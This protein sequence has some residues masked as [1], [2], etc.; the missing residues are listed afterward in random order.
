[1]TLFLDGICSESSTCFGGR[2]SS[3]DIIRFNI[4]LPDSSVMARC[5]SAELEKVTNIKPRAKFWF[6]GMDSLEFQTLVNTG[7]LNKYL[8]TA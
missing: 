7:W 1:M 5:A 2:A 4:F 6:S 8:K 3:R